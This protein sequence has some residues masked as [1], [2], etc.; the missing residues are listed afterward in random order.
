MK[1]LTSL[2]LAL[3]LLAPTA[4]LAYSTADRTNEQFGL[5]ER[6]RQSGEITWREGL[7]LRKEQRDIARVENE[8]ASDGRLNKREKRILHKLQNKAEDHIVSEANDTYHRAWWLP[9]LGR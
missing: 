4:A 1:T 7:K 8:L 5:I 9:R 6:G 3:T 2:T